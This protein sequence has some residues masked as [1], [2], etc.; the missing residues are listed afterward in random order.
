MSKKTTLFLF[1]EPG[2]LTQSIA[3]LTQESEVPVRYPVRPYTFVSPSVDS[4]R[5][6]VSDGRKYV[7]LVLNTW[8]DDLRL[9][10][11]FN[12]ISVISGQ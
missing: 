5:A 12:S 7:H 1:A 2:R 10:V 6:V 3:R 8:M 9:Y 4:R 11:L